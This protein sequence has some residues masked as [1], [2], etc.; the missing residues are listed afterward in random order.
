MMDRVHHDAQCRIENG[1]R[2]FRILPF[3]QRRRA[4]EIRKQGRDGFAFA[5]GCG[6][7]FQGGMLCADP[8]GQMGWRVGGR[9]HGCGL[10]GEGL[11]TG[12]AKARLRR[13]CLLALRADFSL[14]YAAI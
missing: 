5:V 7:C 11:T 12:G 1:A 9:R 3:D 6:A 4:L 13:Q 10:A 14:P 2:D 8:F